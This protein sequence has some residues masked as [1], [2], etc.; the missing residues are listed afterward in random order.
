MSAD[1]SGRR[2]AS[3]E[4][5]AKATLE[6]LESASR[7]PEIEEFTNLR[8]IH[9][10]SRRLTLW[11]ARIGVAP[12]LVSL[13][14]MACGIL[15]GIA[16]FHYASW[17]GAPLGLA[18][19]I[20]WHILDGSDGQL[21]RLTHRQSPFG[22]IIDGICDYVTF[23]SV[24]AGLGLAMAERLGPE[25][26]GLVALAGLAHVVQSAAYELQRQE[27]DFW[28]HDKRSA[29]LTRLEDL[30]ARRGGPLHRLYVRYVQ[31]Q[32]L[33]SGGAVRLRER[34]AAVLAR[35]PEA[36][37]RIR[38]RYREV[39]AGPVRAWA[40]LSS[41]YRT[42]G[43]FLGAVFGVPWLYFLWELVGFSLVMGWRIRAQRRHW[44][45][46]ARFLDE[47]GA[48][49]HDDGTETR[50]PARETAGAH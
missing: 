6:D 19:M 20:A 30:R 8:F 32:Y 25:L 27:Y 2:P 36:Q 9:P 7:T 49:T 1:V 46:F 5:T 21:A 28:G 3:A 31:L 29:E 15:A 24:Y 23:L 37:A 43:I 33:T 22:K 44:H 16:Y 12:N 11:F 14:G 38:A 26:W 17:W 48:G 13:T 4:A 40:L 35:H 45:A 10:A 34:L 41:N 42:L 39:F 18:L 47:F 50:D